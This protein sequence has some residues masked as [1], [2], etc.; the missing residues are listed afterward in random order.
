MLKPISIEPLFGGTEFI[1]E[2][3]RR[4]VETALEV[5]APLVTTVFSE[6]ETEDGVLSLII[7]TE[8]YSSPLDY[9]LMINPAGE[10]RTLE[11]DFSGDPDEF[12]WED[13]TGDYEWTHLLQVGL[14]EEV[15]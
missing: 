13:V 2:A 7:N 11:R 4:T 6:D 5:L 14:I 8:Y 3:Q 12:N 1:T 9:R 10:I 15:W